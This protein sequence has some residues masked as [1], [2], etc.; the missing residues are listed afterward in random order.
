MSGEMDNEIGS[1]VDDEGRLARVEISVKLDPRELRW[2]TSDGLAAA[3]ENRNF[4]DLS[5]TTWA[6]ARDVLRSEEMI[7][8]DQLSRCAHGSILVDLETDDI[9]EVEL[10]EL[11]PMDL[12]TCGATLAL[13]AAGCSTITACAGHVTPYPYIAFWARPAWAPLLIKAAEEAR[14]G[15]GN[16]DNGAAEVF[17]NADDVMGLI[18]FAH[19]LERRAPELLALA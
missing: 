9:D 16:A 7:V 1:T 8:R 18:R 15:L 5:A 6:E 14:I 4:V 12:G 10:A 13:N 2:P 11:G 3:S 17:T 19:E